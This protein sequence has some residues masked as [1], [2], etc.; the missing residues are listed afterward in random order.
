MRIQDFLRKKNK[1]GKCRHLNRYEVV[2][3]ALDEN[4]DQ[5]ADL[6]DRAS[7]LKEAS[8]ILFNSNVGLKMAGMIHDDYFFETKISMPNQVASR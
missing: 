7:F 8:R 3:V 5:E 1:K 4:I 6:E 2:V